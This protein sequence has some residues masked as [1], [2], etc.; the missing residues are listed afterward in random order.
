MKTRWL[1]IGLM[2]GVVL[3]L[4]LALFLAHHR[5]LYSP[6]VAPLDAS[7]DWIATGEGAASNFGYSVSTAGDLNGDGYADVVVDTDRYKQFAG[8]VYVYPGNAH[9]LSVTPILSATGEGGNNHFGYAVDTAGDV[10]LWH[11]RCG[12]P[13][14]WRLPEGWPPPHSET[15]YHGKGP[16]CASAPWPGQRPGAG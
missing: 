11:F 5:H 12:P 6:A 3:V 16:G 1:L 8:R 15:R 9:E 4:T 10:T 14:G 2:A 13:C 7:P